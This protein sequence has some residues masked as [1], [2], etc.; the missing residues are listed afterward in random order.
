M[1]ITR[2]IQSL[3]TFKRR[4]NEMLEQLRE[5]G[6]PLVLTVNGKAELV[7]QDAA[8]Y[9]AIMDRLE[10]LDAIREGL[11]DAAQGRV[12]PAQS[13]IRHLRK[14]HAISRRSDKKG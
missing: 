11:N 7:V 5:T 3:T 8:A 2:D 13:V 9:Q 4:T 10:T 14:K 1:N 12:K 6:E